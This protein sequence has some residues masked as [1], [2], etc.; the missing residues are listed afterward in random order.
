MPPYGPAA[1][2]VTIAISGTFA[3]LTPVEDQGRSVFRPW[4]PSS[5]RRA[6]RHAG[7]RAMN[8]Q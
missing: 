6:K 4:K 1:S 8:H 5:G 7:Q 2:S 3:T